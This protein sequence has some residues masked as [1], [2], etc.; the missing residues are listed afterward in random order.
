MAQ[1]TSAVMA[2]RI[3]ESNNEACEF[4]LT[5]IERLNLKG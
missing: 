5:E 3:A 4:V 2:E 1:K